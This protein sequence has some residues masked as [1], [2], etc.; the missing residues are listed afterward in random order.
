MK[1][2][3]ITK[4]FLGDEELEALRGPIETGWLVQG[5]NV[6][7]FEAMFAERIGVQ[8]AVATS[9]CTSGLHLGLLALGIGPGDAV[10]VPSFTYIATANAVEYC[11]GRPVFCDIDL[12]T[13]NIDVN[14]VEDLCKKE[15][16]IKAVIPV[17]LFGLSADM[18]A[19]L[20]TA[21]R[22]GLRVLE[23]A[24]C[25]LGAESDGRHAGTWRDAAAFSFHPRKPI[26]TGEGGML[27]TNDAAVAEKVRKLRDHGAEASDLERHTK[28][29]G[30]LL[31]EFR[32]LGYNYRMTDLQGAIGVVQMEKADRI[33]DGR[34]AGAA[35]YDAALKDF[36]WLIPPRVPARKIHA[37][38]S[39]VT[40]LSPGEAR[41][42]DLSVMPE[43]NRKRNRFMALLEREGVSTRQG[44][45]AVHTLDYYRKKYGLNEHDF[46]NA[47]LADRL[48]M[49]LPL[50]WNITREDVSEIVGRM[51]EN[52]KK[53]NRDE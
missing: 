6:K 27:T 33:L 11:G 47:L 34:R 1:R 24:A 23:D 13:F 51:E 12:E 4:P 25:A 31:P 46:P 49:A 7:K 44:T 39:Y 21:E 37:Y 45:H 3:P 43:L 14:Q 36:G 53:V 38:Q 2:Y 30:S 40:L 10:I 8:H 28:E 15:K 42:P 22:Y 52:W 20:E 41:R 48:S 29:G 50:Y 26:T 5:P 17:S 16:G 19:V 32:M 18:E 35:L 9:N